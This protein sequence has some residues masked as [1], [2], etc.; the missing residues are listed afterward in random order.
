[1]KILISPAKTLDFTSDVPNVKKT[2]IIFHS[3]A[4]I[5][6]SKLKS[7]SLQELSVLM[8]ISTKLAKLNFDRNQNWNY[9]FDINKT[10]QAIYAFQGDVYQ[11]LQAHTFDIEDI[12]FCQNVL[13]IL[14]GLYGILR[15]LDAI[16]PYRLE[17]GTKIKINSYKNLYKF[18]TKELTSYLNNEM[19]KE[20]ILINLASDEYFKVI[21]KK[22]LHAKIITPIF[23]DYKNG[24]LKVISFY[25]KKARGNMV[26]F[27]VKNRIEKYE[28]LKLFYI[29]D[30]CFDEKLS[31]DRIF[32]F[33]R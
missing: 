17:M 20:E 28:D 12:D 31:D 27:I 4:K 14:S 7:K 9:P 15:P 5:L 19:K 33:T 32:V 6:N 10:K 26:N 2:D 3:Q 29:D 13:R 16:L 30:Y 25:A 21:D 24:K 1:M 18:W 23:K 22:N 8:S 11:G